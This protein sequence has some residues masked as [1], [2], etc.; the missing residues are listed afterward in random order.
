[1]LAVLSG[2]TLPVASW[3]P[4]KPKAN[5]SPAESPT[6][7]TRRGVVAE[8]GCPC[9]APPGLVPSAAWAARQSSS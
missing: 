8:A 4:A 3:K 9:T 7:M 5:A 2:T 6:V 1:M